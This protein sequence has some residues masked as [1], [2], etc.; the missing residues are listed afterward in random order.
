M[1]TLTFSLTN[2]IVVSTDIRSPKSS[3]KAPAAS[4][5]AILLRV[6]LAYVVEYYA[7]VEAAAAC[8]LVPTFKIQTMR[9]LSRRGDVGLHY[10]M[11][12]LKFIDSPAP[13]PTS[14]AT[15][16]VI[17]FYWRK[18]QLIILIK[19]ALPRTPLQV[20]KEALAEITPLP[21]H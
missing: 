16:L 2:D 15:D 20:L 8:Q 14:S 10:Y 3:G 21:L 13:P 9:V 1:V 11:T 17:L 18:Q 7:I 5:V 4:L 19:P 12:P 6:A